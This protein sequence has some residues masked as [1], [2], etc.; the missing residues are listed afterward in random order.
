MVLVSVL[1]FD[2]TPAWNKR[3]LLH[4][5]LLPPQTPPSP[6]PPVPRVSHYCS[7]NFDNFYHFEQLFRFLTTLFKKQKSGNFLKKTQSGTF[8]KRPLKM[9][10]PV[11]RL[12]EMVA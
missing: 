2:S 8:R 7:A 4:V 3:R 9:S 11:G 6:S 10:S 1:R 5:K 12:R